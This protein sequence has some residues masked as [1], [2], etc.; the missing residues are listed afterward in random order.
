MIYMELIFTWTLLY[1]EGNYTNSSFPEG[2]CLYRLYCTL[3]PRIEE[4][5]KM[6]KLASKL[7]LFTVKVFCVLRI[8]RLEYLKR[9]IVDH[10]KTRFQFL[11]RLQNLPL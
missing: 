7:S 11:S 6:T 3:L 5:L 9:N 4:I 8:T 1:V 10:M 2:V